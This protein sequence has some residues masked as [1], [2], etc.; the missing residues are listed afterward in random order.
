MKYM[1]DGH[2]SAKQI[3]EDLAKQNAGDYGEEE[4]GGH[5]QGQGTDDDTSFPIKQTFGP[6]ALDEAERGEFN[7]SEQIDDAEL[8]E[9]GIV[10]P[11]DD[12]KLKKAK[13]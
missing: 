2:K 9:S 1:T 8:R 4:V 11:R 12:E 3:E 7:L 6:S 13:K 10:P 5:M